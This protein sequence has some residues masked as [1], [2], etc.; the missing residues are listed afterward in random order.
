MKFVTT[1]YT[2]KKTILKFPD[3]YV[4]VAVM[5]DATNVAVNDEGKK[6][7]P[8]GTAVG[9]VNGSILTNAKH[10]KVEAK[11]TEGLSSG[12]TGAAVDAEGVLLEDVDCTYGDAPGTMIIHGFL[13]LGKC[14]DIP[15]EARDKMKLICF[16]E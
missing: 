14:K 9:G 5:V 1:D 3:H 4:G 8:A 15:E 16:I 11:M 10:N 2:N 13:D 6:I 7:L 12:E